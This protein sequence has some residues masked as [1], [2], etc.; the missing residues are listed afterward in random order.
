MSDDTMKKL[1][2]KLEG[3]IA[4]LNKLRDDLVALHATVEGKHPV[5]EV[6]TFFDHIWKRRYARGTDEHYEF[7]DADAGAARRW[8][9]TADTRTIFTRIENYF[10]DREPFVVRQKHPFGLLVSRY[11]RY[12]VD[13][14]LQPYAGDIDIEPAA[15]GDCAHT[16][17]CATDHEHTARR[18]QDMRLGGDG[19]QP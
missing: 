14:G 13:R 9:K 18:R 5:K 11:N 6:L 16:P 19:W 3:H 2:V 15:P 12:K 10:N 17:R 4:T 8:L 7:T 1:A